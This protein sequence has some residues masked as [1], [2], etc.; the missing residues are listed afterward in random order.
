MVAKGDGSLGSRAEDDRDYDVVKVKVKKQDKDGNDISGDKVGPGGRRREDG[1]LS[2]MYYDPEPL[3]E[4]QD[5][6]DRKALE[7]QLLDYALEEQRL[8]QERTQETIDLVFYGMERLMEFLADHP[9]VVLKI[10]NGACTFGRNFVG[11]V[12]S[13]TAKLMLK[14]SAIPKKLCPLTKAERILAKEQAVE[15]EDELLLTATGETGR[16][17][18][19]TMS[20]EEARLEV[21]NV[22]THYVEMKKGLQRLSNANVI[23]M[24]KLGF[25]GAI[26]QLENIVKQYPAL[27]D[28][29][30]ETSILAFALDAG[31]RER[32]KITLTASAE[33]AKGR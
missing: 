10:K 16:G 26:A 21:L 2:A 25:E 29:R 32:V 14:K 28:E 7:A 18:P 15:V 9:E 20:I 24:Q 30:T 13:I 33:V 4:S 6:A 17:K 22:L 5:A 23:E 1:T 27:M 8:K 11:G 31:E 3:D 12:K 19:M